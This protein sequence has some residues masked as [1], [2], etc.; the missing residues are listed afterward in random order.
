MILYL[1][2]RYSLWSS[3]VGS[4]L[5][6]GLAYG[7]IYKVFVRLNHPELVFKTNKKPIDFFMDSYASLVQSHVHPNFK[8]KPTCSSGKKYN[9]LGIQGF[10]MAAMPFLDI[11]IIQ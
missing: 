5:F 11:L 6:V 9:K 4:V 1:L 3:T 2:F 8:S 7:I 10:G